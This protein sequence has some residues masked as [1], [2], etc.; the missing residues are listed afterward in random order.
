MGD[1]PILG[2]WRGLDYLEQGDSMIYI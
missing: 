1:E 2:N